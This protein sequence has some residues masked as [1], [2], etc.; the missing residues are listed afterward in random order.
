MKIDTKEKTIE[1]SS[2]ETLGDIF[3]GI[4][5]AFPHTWKEFKISA[6]KVTPWH[7]YNPNPIIPSVPY[8]PWWEYVPS[9]I[10]CTTGTDNACAPCLSGW[11]TSV[12]VN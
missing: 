9:K 11:V 3:N 5:A 10:T 8:I 4:I 6:D 2:E 1:V 7:P 12:T